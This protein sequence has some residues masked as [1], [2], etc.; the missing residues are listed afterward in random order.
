MHFGWRARDKNRNVL[1]GDLEIW[2]EGPENIS[3]GTLK[4]AP[5]QEVVSKS[6]VLEGTSILYENGNE[7]CPVK[8]LKNYLARRPILLT[9]KKNP[10]DPLGVW[11]L[12]NFMKRMAALVNPAK[13]DANHSAC[14]TII[15]TLR[16]ENENH[17]DISQPLGH[18]NFKS[19]DSYSTVQRGNRFSMII[20]DRS[21]GR[22][23]MKPV[24]CK[25][26]N[27]KPNSSTS[28]ASSN[29]STLTSFTSA[30]L[31]SAPLVWVQHPQNS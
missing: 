28:S 3:S 14:R 10:R 12:G 5:R 8:F 25:T 17:L 20:G 4:Q 24:S 22:T 30:V 6:S 27:S 23:L 7:W 2:R 16:H 1:M 9:V 29:Q 18:N 21:S 15:T 11:P 26:P 13:K 31:T 19:I